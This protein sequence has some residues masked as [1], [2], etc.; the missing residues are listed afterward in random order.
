MSLAMR[1]RFI[2]G[3]HGLKWRP[4]STSFLDFCLLTHAFKS[5]Q[6]QIVENDIRSR[7]SE[8]YPTVDKV[9]IEK[10]LKPVL[11]RINRLLDCIREQSFILFLRHSRSRAQFYFF[12]RRAWLRVNN[13]DRPRSNRLFISYLISKQVRLR[14]FLFSLY[15]LVSQFRPRGVL[16]GLFISY[17]YIFTSGQDD[18]WKENSSDGV[19]SGS[20]K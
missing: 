15:G 4:C 14:A 18:I 11:C 20:L 2:V 1:M 7:Y 16:K 19:T 13:D 3:D 17:A 8:E 9:G 12:A 6:K 10:L 5:L